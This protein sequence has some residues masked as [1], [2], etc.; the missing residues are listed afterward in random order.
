MSEN[1]AGAGG[2]T[3]SLLAERSGNGACAISSGG[4]S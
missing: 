3:N 4:R 2:T 1:E